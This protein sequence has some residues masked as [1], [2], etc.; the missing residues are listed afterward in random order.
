M[1][2]G[3]KQKIRQKIQKVKQERKIKK[4]VKKNKSRLYMTTSKEQCLGGMKYEV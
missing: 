2:R 3:K 4:R 1:S